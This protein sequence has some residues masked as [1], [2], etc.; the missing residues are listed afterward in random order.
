M[1]AVILFAVVAALPLPAAAWTRVSGSVGAGPLVGPIKWDGPGNSN[2]GNGQTGDVHLSDTLIAGSVGAG[3]WFASLVTP[4]LALGLGVDLSLVGIGKATLGHTSYGP[5]YQGDVVVRFIYRERP[6]PL[7]Y[8][9][10]VGFAHANFAGGGEDIGSFDNVAVHE[11]LWGPT[12]DFSVGS[13]ALAVQLTAT[14][15]NGNHMRYIP[16]V[17][18]AR[19]HFGTF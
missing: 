17:L 3:V 10:S 16:I 1:R 6:R 14:Y 18:T 19:V 2:F 13:G 8:R 15:F 7:T 12:A 9:F 11:P 5:G 4:R